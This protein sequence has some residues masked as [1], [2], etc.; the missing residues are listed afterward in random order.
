MPNTT[1]KYPIINQDHIIGDSPQIRGVYAEAL[2]IAR[3]D[4]PILILGET[5]TGKDTLAAAIHNARGQGNFVKVNSAAI[6]NTVLESELFGYN[7]GAFTDAKADH[8]GKL[9][10]A[11]KGTVFL[12]EIGDMDLGLQAKLLSVL[13]DNEITPLGA[14]RPIALECRIIAATNKDLEQDVKNGKFRED[15]FYRLNVVS[16]EIPPLR[17]RKKDIPPLAV[18][19]ANK[20]SLKYNK[21]VSFSEEAL[22]FLRKLA[23]NWPGN[24]RELGHLAERAVVL[25]RENDVQP[26]LSV[27]SG[28]LED[29]GS[30]VQENLVMKQLIELSSSPTISL[31]DVITRLND[32]S[33]VAYSLYETSRRQVVQ[34]KG[35]IIDPDYLI[36]A[37]KPFK[38]IVFVDGEYKFKDLIPTVEGY[39]GNLTLEDVERTIVLNRLKF[40]K[41]NKAATARSLDIDV[42]TIYNLLKKWGIEI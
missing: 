8:P 37:H 7:R 34:N 10:Y 2:S 21:N 16:F 18:Y 32:I 41:D 24:I 14:N 35:G 26:L 9:V 20:Y 6:P 1:A 29:V 27:D 28:V 30:G 4:V 23:Y 12:T 22:D 3:T 17:D 40:F 5:G 11:G 15:L 36:H 39:Y 13:D 19:F 38:N 31:L 33:Q 42:K 25:F